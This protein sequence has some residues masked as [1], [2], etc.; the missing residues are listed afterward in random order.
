MK[1]AVVEDEAPAREVLV[2]AIREAEPGAAIVAELESVAATVRWLETHGS[3]DLL[4]LDIQL[5]DGRSFEIF[6]RTRVACP[7]IFATAYDSFLLEAFH[8]NGIDYLLKP[9]RTERVAGALDKYRRLR[10]HFVADYSS[11]ATGLAPGGSP[12]R[13]RFLVRKGTDLQSVA[14]SEIAYFFASGG[15]RFLVTRKGLRYQVDQSLSELEAELPR[16]DF[17]RANRAF[18]VHASCLRKLSPCG[19]GKLIAE[20]YPQ[21]EVE[22]IVSQERAPELRLWLDR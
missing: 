9:I 1:I 15:L 19:K 7:V 14:V 3:P 10:D 5:A 20:L 2:R 17:F 21:C 6:G 13:S 11:L 12:A 18:L 4:F 22:C 16:Q 8:A